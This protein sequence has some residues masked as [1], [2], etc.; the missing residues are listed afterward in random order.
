MSYQASFFVQ[1]VN[2]RHDWNLVDIYLDFKSGESIRERPEFNRMLMDAEIGKIDIILTKSISRFGRNTEETISALRELK[3]RGVSVIFDQESIDTATADSELV[4]SILS[5]FAEE[6]NKS[7]RDDQNWGIE[8][9]LNDG[10]SEIYKRACYGYKKD[11]SGEL[12]IDTEKAKVVQDIFEMYLSGKSIVGIISELEVKGIKS[13]TGKDKWSKRT[14]DTM[15]SNEKYTGDVLAFKTFSIYTPSHKRIKNNE[16]Y[17]KQ[18]LRTNLQPAIISKEIF[19]EVQ[20]EK[21]RRTNIVT[22]EFGTHRKSTKYSSK[23]CV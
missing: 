21:T 16:G 15:L 13:P 20:K 17:H 2:E 4:I 23:A 7:R 3:D 10:T 6:E 8:K 5:A 14:I 11:A 22:D 19:K 18:Y 1:M 9:R 12:I